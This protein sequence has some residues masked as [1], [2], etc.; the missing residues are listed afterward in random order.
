M[1]INYKKSGVNID[2]GNELVRRIKKSLPSIGGFSGIFPFKHTKF[3]LVGSCDGVGTKLKLAF[4]LNKHDT[5]GIDLVAMNVND[6]ICCGAKPLFFLD[7]F[8]CGQLN[9][10]T[11]EHVIKGI[12]KGCEQAGCT[13]LGGETAEMP[14][15]YAKGE[16]DLAGFAVGSVERGRRI[17]GKKIKPGDVLIGLPSSG[18]HSNGYSLIRKVL[19]ESELRKYS[20]ELLAPTRIYVK[21]ILRLFGV[22]NISL[23]SGISHITGGGFYDNIERLLPKNT[24]AM[25]DKSTWE[26][27]EIFKLIKSKGKISKKEMYRT[28]NMGIGM[29]LI[30]DRKRAYNINQMLKGSRMIGAIVRGKGKVKVV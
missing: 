6:L 2:K 9:V 16:Y 18:P 7:Y 5:I 20:K 17:T 19:S 12:L 24:N 28:F 26:V 29:V 8:A 14:G 21:D 30:C 11:A 4:L 22:F 15:F 23:F 1:S 13:L 3:N 25:I 10:D 27:P